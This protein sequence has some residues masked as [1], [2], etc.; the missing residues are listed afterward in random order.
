MSERPNSRSR[1]YSAE[2][3]AFAARFLRESPWCWGC[4]SIN[5]RTPAVVLDHIV[6]V[7]NAPDR[8][9]DVSNVQPLCRCC[10]DRAKRQLET[11]WRAGKIGVD[12]LR[13]GSPVAIAEVRRHH[14]PA[15]G[16]DG[17]AIR[18]T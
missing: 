4:T 5:V 12:A 18:G 8:V 16:L 11:Q 3:S 14:R 17:F 1:G 9:L 7:V 15:I 6:P 10:H 13:M 2:W